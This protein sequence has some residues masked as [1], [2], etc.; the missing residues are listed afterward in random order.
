MPYGDVCPAGSYCP[1][2]TAVPIPCP[3]GTYLDVI[4]AGDVSDCLACSP[5]NGFSFVN[6]CTRDW[7]V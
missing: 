6:F 3:S 1:N 4:Q 5:G 7:T 2:A